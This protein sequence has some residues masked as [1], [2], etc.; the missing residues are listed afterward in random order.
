MKGQV[1]RQYQNVL[2][3]ADI[4]ADSEIDVGKMIVTQL[5]NAV[6]ASADYRIERV[7]QSYNSVLG[8]VAQAVVC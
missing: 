6:R 2:T 5:I 3:W 7:I 8:D 1:S 4:F